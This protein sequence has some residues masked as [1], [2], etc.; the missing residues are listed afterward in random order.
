MLS[1]FVPDTQ[2]LTSLFDE[3]FFA[4]HQPIMQIVDKMNK[5]LGADKI[6]LASMDIQKTWK[7]NQKSLSPRHS[8]DLQQIIRVKA[9]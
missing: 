7:M 1:E 8:T 4:K 6:K 2:R 9:E 5:R 3:D